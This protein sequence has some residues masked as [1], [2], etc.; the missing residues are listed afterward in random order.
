MG[1][2]YGSHNGFNHSTFATQKFS[3]TGDAYLT[4]VV[5]EDGDGDEFYDIGEG[6]G[7]V[8]ITAYNSSDVYGASTHNSGGY[9]LE[10]PPG[11][12]T[13]AFEGGSL[14][15]IYETEVTIGNENVKLDLIED[16]T[17]T[18]VVTLSAIPTPDAVSQGQA[19]MN[20]ITL[21]FVP[22]EETVFLEDEIDPLLLAEL[23]V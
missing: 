5:I 3:N 19:L 23:A 15:G 14:D 13:V 1:Y 7:G 8:R 10:L 4:G 20:A 2:D 18:S 21:D 9:A 12:Y 6:Q 16:A 11:T 17:G 22:D